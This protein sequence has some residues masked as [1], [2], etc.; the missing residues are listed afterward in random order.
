MDNDSCHNCAIAINIVQVLDGRYSCEDCMEIVLK[1]FFS[2]KWEEL[3]E[4]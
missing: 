2:E 4:G 3:R 1:S